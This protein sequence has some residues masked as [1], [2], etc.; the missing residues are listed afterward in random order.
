[1]GTKIVQLNAKQMKRFVCF[2]F[3]LYAECPYWIPPLIKDEIRSLSPKYNP[4]FHRGDAAF[5]L[6]VQSGKV[7]GR[8]AA[9]INRIELEYQ[10]VNKG[11][12]GWFDVI[13]DVEVAKLLLSQ[14]ES[15][16]K[17][18]GMNYVEGPLGFSNLDRAGCLVEG[19]EEL[20]NITTIYN[21]PYYEDLLLQCGYRKAMDW[22]EYRIEVP[23]HVSEDLGRFAKL[24]S[25]RLKIRLV[26]TDSVSDL[27]QYTEA[28]FD[29]L[30]RTHAHL[31]GFVPFDR[32][33]I[34]YYKK[35]FGQFL[36]PDYTAIVVDRDNNLIGFGLA[37]PSMS[38]AFKKAKGRLFPLGWWHIRKALKRNDTVDLMLI[39]VDSSYRNK[40][41]PALIF[42]AFSKGLYKN[43]IR[44]LESNPELEDN[45]NVQRL[46]AK[47]PHRLHK[48]RR[49]FVKDL[50]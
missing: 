10:A 33:I 20:G 4:A 47:Y 25:K 11:R 26:K 9:L 35:K 42:Y 40:G 34:Q 37:V 36:H 39:G 27:L 13:N 32:Q 2:P 12:F 24:I 22:V 43:G 16:L 6:A 21:Y 7:V 46:W 44:W 28:I 30:N 49:S 29:L 41:V 31:H 19:F 38:E 50:G 5:F 23:Q 15:W 45:T 14:A 3:D 48:R 18:R 17:A 1:M 8:I